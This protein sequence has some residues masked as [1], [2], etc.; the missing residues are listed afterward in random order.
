MKEKLIEQIVRNVRNP[1]FY[2]LLI[3]LLVLVLLLFPYIDA[4]YF[5]YNR[6]RQRVEILDKICQIDLQIIQNNEV[7]TSEYN[8]ILEEISIQKNNSLNS[9]F[10]KETNKTV[11]TNKFISGAIVLFILG[12]ISIFLKYESVIYKFFAFIIFGIMSIIFGYVAVLIPTIISPTFNY[13]FAPLLELFVIFVFAIETNN[14]H[15]NK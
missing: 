1:K 13:V 15:I 6:V 9:I 12:I 5:Y 7:L 2:I 4:N 8:S 10:I 11:N 3:I 14:T